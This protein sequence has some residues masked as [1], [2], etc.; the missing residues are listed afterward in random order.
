MS[1]QLS[2]KPNPVA[3]PDPNYPGSQHLHDSR[4]C[5]FLGGYGTIDIYWCQDSILGRFSSKDSDY[6]S[7]M[8]PFALAGP[9]EYLW[10]A[11]GWY[12]RALYRAELWRPLVGAEPNDRG[13]P[14]CQ[15]GPE[16]VAAK[17]PERLYV[18]SAS[19]PALGSWERLGELYVR[20]E[21]RYRNP[22][23]GQGC[24]VL[25][26]LRLGAEERM[27]QVYKGPG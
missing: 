9:E 14:G 16:V 8:S 11:A 22:A 21:K 15:A 26:F 27:S 20:T 25:D 23:T 13:L 2:F 17:T 6:A 12:H 19:V 3:K 5:V 1:K 7:C 18:G 24:T 10:H 4:C